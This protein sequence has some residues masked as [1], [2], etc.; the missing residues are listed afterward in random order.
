MYLFA[1][2]CLTN[3]EV[4]LYEYLPVHVHVHIGYLEEIESWREG[5]L[6]SFSLLCC[7]CGEGMLG[8]EA[9]L[10]SAKAGGWW[11]FS[12]LCLISFL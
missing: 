12:G 8:I 2:N 4:I 10:A 11:A 1:E 6:D 5:C 9:L 3:T 7:V